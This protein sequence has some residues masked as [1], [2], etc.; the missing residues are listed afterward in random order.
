MKQFIETKPDFGES[1]RGGGKIFRGG[2]TIISRTKHGLATRT[3][4][5]NLVFTQTPLPCLQSLC[6]INHGILYFFIKLV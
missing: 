5:A 2:A 4:Y 1:V 6:T 3:V